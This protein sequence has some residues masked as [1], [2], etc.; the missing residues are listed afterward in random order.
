MAGDRRSRAT[1]LSLGALV[2]SICRAVARLPFPTQR[3]AC[4]VV[5]RVW[6]GRK[7]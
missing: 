4:Q 6:R 2:K 5:R 1:E 3:A 7:A